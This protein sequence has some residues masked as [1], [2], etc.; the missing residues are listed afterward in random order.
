M[1]FESNRRGGWWHGLKTVRCTVIT[2]GMLWSGATS[3]LG[4]PPAAYKPARTAEGQPDLNGF[5]Q[6]MNTANWDIEE[7]AAEAGPYSNLLGAYLAEPAGL[8]VVEGGTI[9]YKPEALAKRDRYRQERLQPDPLLLENGTQDFADPEA[10]CFQG[11]VPRATYMAFPF[12]ILQNKTSVLIAYEFGGSLGR[13]VRLGADLDKTRSALV[14][15]DSWMGQS[16]GRFEGDTLVI[17]VKWFSHEIW[18][19]RAGNFYSEGAHVVERYT[20][21]SPYHLRYEA[22]IDD[23]KVFTRPWKISMLLYKHVEPDMQLLEFQCIPLA[24]EFLYGKLYKK[25]ADR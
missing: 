19:D 9:P 6:A 5:W 22:T 10:K 8:S 7:H 15:S 23:P 4:Q 13:V 16:V 24:E 12:Q 14:P 18:L 20:P 21:I 1:R 25:K 2:L 17:D 11:G 3:A